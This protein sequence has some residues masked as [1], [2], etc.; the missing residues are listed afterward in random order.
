[1]HR[2]EHVKYQRTE[3]EFATMASAGTMFEK[4]GDVKASSSNLN[5]E[6]GAVRILDPDAMRLGDTDTDLMDMMRLGKK[7]EFKV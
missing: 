6:M 4:D 7:Q 5:R 2:Y 3:I 1:M